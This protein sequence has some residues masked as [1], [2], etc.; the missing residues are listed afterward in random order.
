MGFKA[1]RN[2]GVLALAGATLVGCTTGTAQKDTKVVAPTPPNNTNNAWNTPANQAA[3]D[4]R[5]PMW[6]TSQQQPQQPQQFPTNPNPAL[7]QRPTTTNFQANPNPGL[8]QYG[9]QSINGGTQ[10]PSTSGGNTY[11]TQP[12][13]PVTQP[14]YPQQPSITMPAQPNASNFGTGSSMSPNDIPAMPPIPNA[15]APNG[16]GSFTPLAPPPAFGNSPR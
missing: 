8:N 4:P 15:L 9:P 7:Q 11:V 12:N 13:M 6:N 14:G 3:P 5:G 1:W 16:T 10:I 2:L